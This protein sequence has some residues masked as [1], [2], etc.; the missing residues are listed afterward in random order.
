MLVR[1]EQ[2]QD[3]ALADAAPFEL[4]SLRV[5]PPLLQVIGPDAA[6]H[7]T[8][9]PRVMQVLVHL[10]R[11]EGQVVSRQDLLNHCWDGRIVGD[12]AIHRVMSRLRALAGET[13]AF[14]IETI[15]RVGYRLQTSALP[16]P[17]DVP[18]VRAVAGPAGAAPVAVPV[19]PTPAMP[20]RM[21]L[22]AG[23]GAG[24]MA[25]AGAAAWR[26]WPAA[27]PDGADRLV[28]KAREAL[29]D[30]LP[31]GTAQAITYLEQA[32]A[33]QPGHGAAWGALALALTVQMQQKP[34]AELPLIA[35]R[36]REAAARAIAI[37]PGNI[38]AR[39]AAATIQPNFRHWLENERAL[40]ALEARFGRH[41]AIDAALGW[42]LCDTGRWRDA[43]VRFRAALAAEP[44]HPHNRMVLALGLWGTG[45]LAEA[46]R[47]FADAMALWPQHPEIWLNRFIFL[48]TTGRPAEGQAMMR[49][50][51]R[52]PAPAPGSD[53][54]PF[55]VL[56][57]FAQARLTGRADDI[58]RAKAALGT[59]LQPGPLGFR[60]NFILAMGSVDDVYS[61]LDRDF[62]GAP[63][64]PAPSP[65]TRRKTSPLFFGGPLIERDPRYRPMLRRLGLQDYWRIS[66]TRPDNPF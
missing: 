36:A 9:E 34:D 57:L 33:S 16:A 43:V 41:Q 2:E 65:L 66:G 5:I 10:A 3:V 62:F 19:V 32:V 1:L 29:L 8:L 27:A 18:V 42:L 35:S 38:E 44:F 11:N 28:A 17:V 55:G 21:L 56:D 46:D 59:P 63:G 12:N 52:R 6:D 37:D 54:L 49:D 31:P 25:A 40:L 53:A 39:V 30:G 23:L 4:G 26:W 47:I 58:A 20:R 45:D 15:A 13:G 24:V 7:R 64:W 50:T 51:A 22:G 14:S 48:V 60:I 61:W